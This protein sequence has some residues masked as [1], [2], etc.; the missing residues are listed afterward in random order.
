MHLTNCSIRYLIVQVKEALTVLILQ[1][2]AV[3]DTGE[4]LGVEYRVRVD[5]ILKRSRYEKFIYCSKKLHGDVAETI[6]EELLLHG[7]TTQ[8]RLVESTLEKL[9]QNTEG[10]YI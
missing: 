1:N 7:Q 5:Q 6:I 10:I 9:R 8:N 3:F 2:I 4:K